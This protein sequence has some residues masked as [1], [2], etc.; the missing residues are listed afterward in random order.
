MAVLLLSYVESDVNEF[1]GP[2]DKTLELLDTKNAQYLVFYQH[3]CSLRMRR[4]RPKKTAN[5][6]V[7]DHKKKSSNAQYSEFFSH[8]HILP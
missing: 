6:L 1:M 3:I 2:M 5:W 7:S 8:H 4:L